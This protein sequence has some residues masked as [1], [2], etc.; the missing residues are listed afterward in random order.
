MIHGWLRKSLN[1]AHLPSSI[2][3]TCERCRMFVEIDTRP[4]WT[5]EEPPRYVLRI[6][7]CPKCPKDSRWI[8]VDD[9]IAFAK[10]EPLYMCWKQKCQSAVASRVVL[11]QTS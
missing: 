5:I 8:P 9:S 1:A 2:K 4:L 7:K 10:R 6:P 11:Y 3:T